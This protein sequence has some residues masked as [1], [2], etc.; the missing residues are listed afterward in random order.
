MRC[1][2]DVTKSWIKLG[3]PVWPAEGTAVKS[4]IS[5]V[6]FFLELHF[7]IFL[8]TTPSSSLLPVTNGVPRIILWLKCNRMSNK[9]EP[10]FDIYVCSSP[11]VH[12]VINNGKWNLARWTLNLVFLS[13]QKSVMVNEIIKRYWSGKKVAYLRPLYLTTLF[14]FS[15]GARL[16]WT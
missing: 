9:T 14:S 1:E 8:G 12:E 16:N 10:L 13:E 7:P 11:T 5:L 3:S 6:L 15:R 2:A 4:H